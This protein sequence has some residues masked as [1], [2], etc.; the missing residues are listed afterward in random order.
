MKAISFY[1]E[2]RLITIKI[3]LQKTFFTFFNKNPKLEIQE[4][5]LFLGLRSRAGVLQRYGY[6]GKI[7]IR[8]RSKDPCASNPCKNGGLCAKNN[9][10]TDFVCMCP[11]EFKGK[12][13][14]NSSTKPSI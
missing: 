1:L 7:G 4:I 2:L 8:S 9:G 6:R 14:S 5:F 10:G 12:T 3:K 11:M 13:C